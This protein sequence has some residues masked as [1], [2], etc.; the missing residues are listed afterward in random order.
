[1]QLTPTEAAKVAG[2]SPAILRDWRRRGLTTL[3]KLE[4][5][6]ADAMRLLVNFG[7]P[8][9]YALRFRVEEVGIGVGLT[10]IPRRNAEALHG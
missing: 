2:V 10:L 9:V 7:I 6:M 4:P 3:R 8:P 1:M 5:E